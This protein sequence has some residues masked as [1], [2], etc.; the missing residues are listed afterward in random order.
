MSKRRKRETPRPIRRR[1]DRPP[2]CP[3]CGV[4][5][6][7]VV[8]GDG[9]RFV[10]LECGFS[11]E[12][13][14]TSRSDHAADAVLGLHQLEAA[15]DLV[16]R[17]RVRD[18][19]R[20]VEPPV[21]RQADELRHLVAALDAAERRAADAAAGDQVPR[22]DVERLALAGDAGDRA[23]APAHARRLDRLAHHVGAARRL[24]G[25]VGAE[26]AGQ[27][28]DLL[29]GVRPARRAWSSRPG[30]AP[31]RAGPRRGRRR[32]SARRPAG[33]SPQRRRARPC[34]RRRRRRSSPPRRAR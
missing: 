11:D 9:V 32:R 10:C 12:S 24:E 30:R 27:L 13:A 31:A 29:D 28:E 20:D 17:Q 19:R 25:V 2:I 21:E 5:Q 15:V 18:E 34:P 3:A 4:T 23:E 26:A 33:G 7:F 16:E 8:E 14:P 22:H 1:D 6:G